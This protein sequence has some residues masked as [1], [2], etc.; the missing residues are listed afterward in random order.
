MYTEAEI[1]A[2]IASDEYHNAVERTDG[3]ARM[4]EVLV[5]VDVALTAAVSTSSPYLETGLLVLR[6]ACAAGLGRLGEALDAARR[7]THQ[8]IASGA[9]LGE[10]DARSVVAHVLARMGDDIGAETERSTAQALIEELGLSV[11][12]PARRLFDRAELA[13]FARLA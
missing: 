7:A 9:R 6:A 1:L 5:A 13:R 3:H 10:L 4:G 12:A 8:H 2:N 11:G